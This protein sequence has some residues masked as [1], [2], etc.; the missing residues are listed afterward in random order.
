MNLPDGA[1]TYVSATRGFKSGGFNIST[2]EPGLGYAPEWAWSYEGGLKTRLADG[3][4]HLSL[5]AF[6]TDYRD[7]QVQ[8]AVRPGVIDI[9][10]AAEATIRGVELEGVTRLAETWE[11][12]G[13]V[14]WLDATYDRYVAVG[15][16]GIAGDVSG[17]RLNNAPE[18][19]G[20]VWLEW[21]RRLGPRGDLSLRGDSRWQST[22][23]FT[24]FNDTI[25]RQRPY[26]LLDAQAQFA[27]GGR[28][29]VG[30]FARN[31]TNEDF[32]TGTFSS[33]IPAIGGRPGHPRQVG[34]QVAV[35]P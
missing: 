2:R 24:P 26:G 13:H 23:Y 5:A 7:L 17:N 34:V 14:A 19:S 6:Y 11:A 28:W 35:E 8:T 3:R 25:Q 18:W 30:M 4:S 31:L 27:F 33:P 21:H 16:A 32:I 9:S 20:R 29:T 15:T 22:A 10:N 1:L 12:G